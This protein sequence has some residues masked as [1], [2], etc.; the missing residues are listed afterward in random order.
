[1]TFDNQFVRDLVA[2]RRAGIF[3]AVWIDADRVQVQRELWDDPQYITREKAQRLIAEWKGEQLVAW[4]TRAMSCRQH[5]EEGNGMSEYSTL[6][7]AIALDITERQLQVWDETNLVKPQHIGHRRVY[8][9]RD[10]AE[11]ELVINLRRK[12]LSI[13]KIK[14]V[15]AHSRK[16]LEPGM[17]L[18]T[19]GRTTHFDH[20]RSH[21]LEIL[22]NA[23]CPMVLVEI[24][25]FLAAGKRVH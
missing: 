7:V 1:M 6:Q 23:H 17:L 14:R 18:V 21:I 2:M 15:M 16:Y 11:A 5:R 9:S 3:Q 25:P 12:G 24:R 19:D 10:A 4:K 20:D 13:Q 8:D 22:K